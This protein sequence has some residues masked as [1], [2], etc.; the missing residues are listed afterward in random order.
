M[1]KER[2]DKIEHLAMSLEIEL[3]SATCND[4][5][6]DERTKELAERYLE[7]ATTLRKRLVRTFSP[8]G[9]LTHGQ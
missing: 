5:G 8:T 1:T 3:D 6:E 4:G 7:Q 2:Y 9:E